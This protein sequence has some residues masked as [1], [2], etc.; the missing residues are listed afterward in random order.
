MTDG[1]KPIDH[2]ALNRYVD[3]EL[4]PET[5]RKVERHLAE[6]PGDEERVRAYQAQSAALHRAYAHVLDEPI[7]DRLLDTVHGDRGEEGKRS[8]WGPAAA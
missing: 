8:A 1:D 7:P 6:N 5:R 3:G 4:D 2:E